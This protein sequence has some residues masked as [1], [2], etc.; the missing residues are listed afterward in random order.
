MTTAQAV[1]SAL[2]KGGHTKS[3]S[4]KS[5]QIKG[6]TERTRGFRA[7]KWDDN[8]TVAV[9]HATGSFRGGDPLPDLAKYEITL[10]DAGFTVTKDDSSFTK[11]LLVTKTR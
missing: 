5:G 11:R 4:W 2:A 3:T 9:E 8:G 7:Y 6:W 1:N 10:T